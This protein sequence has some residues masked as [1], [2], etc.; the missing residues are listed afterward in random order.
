[1]GFKPDFTQRSYLYQQKAQ[2]QQIIERNTQLT[3][4]MLQTLPPHREYI[5]NWLATLR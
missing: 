3:Q 4:Q 2:A 1:M 5:E